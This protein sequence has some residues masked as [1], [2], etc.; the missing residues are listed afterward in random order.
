MRE[1]GHMSCEAE[2]IGGHLTVAV[3]EFEDGDLSREDFIGKLLV[4]SD[5]A[6]DA[7]ED[8]EITDEEYASIQEE[9]REVMERFGISYEESGLAL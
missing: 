3:G 6:Q 2:R 5:D 8:D 7:N 4:I 9:L 1:V